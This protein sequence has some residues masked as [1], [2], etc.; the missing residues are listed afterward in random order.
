MS[1]PLSFAS[2][3]VLFVA[4]ALTTQLDRVKAHCY[5]SAANILSANMK[6]LENVWEKEKSVKKSPLY[7]LTVTKILI[8]GLHINECYGFLKQESDH[9]FNKAPSEIIKNLKTNAQELTRGPIQFYGVE[10]PEKATV[11][12]LGTTVKIELGTFMSL[13]QAVLGP[14]L[15]LW[16][17]SLYNTRYRESLLISRASSIAEIFPHLINIYPVGRLP[18]ARKKSWIIYYLPLPVLI[19][20]LYAITRAGLLA[21]FVVPPAAAYIASL[22]IFPPDHYIAIFLSFSLLI[23]VNSLAVIMGEFYPWHFKKIFPGLDRHR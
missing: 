22:I 7:Y 20:F 18:D 17:G 4:I 2:I 9:H 5:E 1:A 11:G 8:F 23:C 16:F 15:I 12:L 14:V 21:V 10:I 6:E 3:L 13:F 19:G